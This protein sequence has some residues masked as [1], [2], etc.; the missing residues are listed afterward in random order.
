MEGLES[1]RGNA[2]A[3]MHFDVDSDGGNLLI[4]YLHPK[5]Y[6]FTEESPLRSKT[7]PQEWY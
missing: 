2:E 6:F 3:L 4:D 1:P 7:F 5:V